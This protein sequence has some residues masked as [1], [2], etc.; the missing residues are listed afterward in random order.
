[1]LGNE[2]V[3][4]RIVGTGSYLPEKVL[5]NRD[6]ESTVDTT[7]EWIRSRTGIEQWRIAAEK[8]SPLNKTA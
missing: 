7:D 1:M 8:N 4:I 3:G 5:T 6:L 2:T